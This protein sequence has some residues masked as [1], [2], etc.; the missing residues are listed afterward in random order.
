MT[1]ALIAQQGAGEPTTPTPYPD[2]LIVHHADGTITYPDAYTGERVVQWGDEWFH[3]LGFYFDRDYGWEWL[4]F[5][6]FD[7]WFAGELELIFF[8]LVVVT[9]LVLPFLPGLRPRRLRASFGWAGCITV[10]TA[11]FTLLTADSSWEDLELSFPIIPAGLLFWWSSSAPTAWRARTWR[12]GLAAVLLL[13]PWIPLGILESDWYRDEAIWGA[14]CFAAMLPL[15]LNRRV[16]LLQGA[17]R[18]VIACIP[19]LFF[20]VNLLDPTPSFSPWASH[21]LPMAIAL[22]LVFPRRAAP[23]L[24]TAL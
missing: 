16:D 19:I 10:G 17:Q 13:F 11:A 20:L 5:N 8:S 6:L 22:F 15:A 7:H 18:W 14:A 23:K 12:V 9:W 2:G 1:Q 4:G 21:A 3:S 24:A